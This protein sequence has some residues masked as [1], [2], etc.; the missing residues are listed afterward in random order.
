[1]CLFSTF[2]LNHCRSE[3]R[4]EIHGQHW[5]PSRITGWCKVCWSC[6]PSKPLA[7]RCTIT[8]IQVTLVSLSCNSL[9]LW[10][11]TY[12]I[13]FS[14]NYSKLGIHFWCTLKER[15]VLQRKIISSEVTPP[16][17]RGKVSQQNTNDLIK[18][19]QDNGGVLKSFPKNGH[20]S[21][22]LFCPSGS[23]FEDWPIT[24]DI[25]W[26]GVI[27][28]EQKV[29]SSYSTFDVSPCFFYLFLDSLV[30]L[31]ESLVVDWNISQY[32]CSLYAI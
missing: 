21:F 32:R 23:H 3:K 25:L 11:N 22:I 26:I 30:H 14:S 19:I 10:C 6:S 20:R 17:G 7:T 12:K 16:N 8:W 9:G 4:D 5:T 24:L 28:G 2:L 18:I 15:H 1:M 13:D 31:W 29:M 27:R